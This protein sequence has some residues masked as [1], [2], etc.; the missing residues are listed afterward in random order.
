MKKLI[1]FVIFTYLV[2]LFSGFSYAQSNQQVIDIAYL[3][4]SWG[5]NLAYSLA[6]SEIVTKYVPEIRS[7]LVKSAGS[8]MNTQMAAT[9][10]PNSIMYHTTSMDFVASYLGVSPWEEAYPNQRLLTS[11]TP[12]ALSFVGS[13]QGAEMKDMVGHSISVLPLP[14]LQLAF[15]NNVLELL[16]LTG[17]VKVVQLDFGANEDALRDGTTSGLLCSIY[18]PPGYETLSPAMQEVLYALKNKLF[19]IRIPKEVVAEACTKLKS[20]FGVREIEP[21]DDMLP[22]ETRTN[23]GQTLTFSALSVRGD[24]DEDIAYKM[25]KAI[26]EHTDEFA[27]YDPNGKF[28]NPKSIAESL[29]YATPDMIHPGAAKYYKEV[30]LWDIYLEA[31]KKFVSDVGEYE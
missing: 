23:F 8:E 3:A 19:W 20:G 24:M 2:L 16:N 31:R 13:V 29:A 28:V 21:G 18:G 1:I 5:E 26:L 15:A 17:K 7:S 10:A 30:G 12:G 4:G 25:T 9:M 6:G 27:D 14:S 22:E 11:Y